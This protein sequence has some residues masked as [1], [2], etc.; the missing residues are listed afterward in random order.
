MQNSRVNKKWKLEDLLLP[1]AM[2][3]SPS[4]GLPDI[5]ATTPP[6][7]TIAVPL[8]D[9]F[10]ATQKD[11]IRCDAPNQNAYCFKVQICT[12][13]SGSCSAAGSYIEPVFAI[14]FL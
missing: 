6:S 8:C 10:A 7:A 12:T 13:G 11:C 3:A 9:N 14:T 4:P 5:A 1:K 2:A